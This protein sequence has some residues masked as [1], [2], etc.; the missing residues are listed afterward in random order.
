MRL[1]GALLVLGAMACGDSTV[2]QRV[3]EID[4]N[5]PSAGEVT[6]FP[7][8]CP[9][10]GNDDASADADLHATGC[11]PVVVSIPPPMTDATP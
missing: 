6:T 1:V 3:T 5:L 4:P 7:A 8:I 2:S 10:S 9:D 11:A